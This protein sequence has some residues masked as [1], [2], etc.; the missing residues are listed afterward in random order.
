M[1]K[2]YFTVKT[3]VNSSYQEKISLTSTCTNGVMQSFEGPFYLLFVFPSVSGS[4]MSSD[5]GEYERVDLYPAHSES[6]DWE[7]TLDLDNLPAI[8]AAIYNPNLTVEEVE[9][10]VIAHPLC[11]GTGAMFHTVVMLLHTSIQVC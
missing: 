7:A 5:E 11:L 4:I 8:H 3:E 6:E 9:A 1:L 10:M 2:E